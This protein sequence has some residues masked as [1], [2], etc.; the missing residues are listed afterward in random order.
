MA[1]PSQ[2]GSL[3]SHEGQTGTAMI[4]TNTI[5]PFLGY[6]AFMNIIHNIQ[7]YYS[8]FNELSHENYSIHLKDVK[9]T[10]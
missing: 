10:R 6:E 1:K 7:Y 8:M 5:K 9:I 3:I 4:F 2:V